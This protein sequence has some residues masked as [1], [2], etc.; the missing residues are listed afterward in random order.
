M[1]TNRR[2]FALLPSLAMAALLAGGSLALPGP[3][4]AYDAPNTCAGATSGVARNTWL[5]GTLSTSTDVDWYREHLKRMKQV[6]FNWVRCHT[7]VPGEPFLQAA[8]EL[9]VLIQVEPPV[10]Y[11]LD[12]WNEILTACR[13]HPSVAIYCCGNEELLDE[14]KIAML[15]Q[16]AAELRQRVPDALEPTL[17][18]HAER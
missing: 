2:P 8:D 12:Q 1:T 11:S 17:A 6:G 13:R 5:S 15:A 10:G 18:R 14:P 9:G 16:C 7:W 4:A 3:V